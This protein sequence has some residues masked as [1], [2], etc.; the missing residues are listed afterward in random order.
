VALDNKLTLLTDNLE[1]FPVEGL[2]LFPLPK[3]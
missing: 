2:L 1:D 3:N